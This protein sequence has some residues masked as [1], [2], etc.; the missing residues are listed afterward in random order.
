MCV[1]TIL[2]GSRSLTKFKVDEGS[3]QIKILDRVS[4]YVVFKILVGGLLSTCNNGYSYQSK[5][6]NSS[7]QTIEAIAVCLFVLMKLHMEGPTSALP[8]LCTHRRT[9]MY[10]EIN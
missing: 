8:V 3:S 7:K 9:Y 10:Q 4:T 1:C 6:S 2:S 5:T